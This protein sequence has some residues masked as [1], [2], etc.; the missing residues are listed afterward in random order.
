MLFD[1]NDFY[2]RTMHTPDTPQRAALRGTLRE[3]SKILIPLHRRLIDVTKDDYAFEVG[4]IGS[5]SQLLRLVTDAPF[6]AWLKPVTSLIVDID[7]M[8]RTDFEATDAAAIAERLDRL[9]GAA[10]DPA[11]AERYVPLLQRDVDVTMGHAAL[12]QAAQ[13]L[14]KT[15]AAP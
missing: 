7:E 12:R 1:K 15:Q 6:F 3:I 11:F 10:A 13:K 9:F 8:A 14:G 2:A 4:P 5:P